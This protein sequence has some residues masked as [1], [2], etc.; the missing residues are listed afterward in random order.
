MFSFFFY[1]CID[2]SVPAW[3]I[4]CFRLQLRA[5]QTTHSYILPWEALSGLSLWTK[6]VPWIISSVPS[7]ISYYLDLTH[8]SSTIQLSPLPAS[9][10]YLHQPR[11][12]SSLLGTVTWVL[13]QWVASLITWESILSLLERDP[14]IPEPHTDHQPQRSLEEVWPS[15]LILQV[16][17]LKPRG[18][19]NCPR[20]HRTLSLKTPIWIDSWQL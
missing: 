19:E 1:N 10:R 3:W 18:K 11:G 7:A 13:L 20:S 6:T 5:R 9:P 17:K 14:Q 4:L 16:M 8:S 15:S 2:V 12:V